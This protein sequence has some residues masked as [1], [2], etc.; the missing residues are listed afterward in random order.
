M[1]VE[2]LT[3]KEL[4]R[5]LKCSL[6]GIRQWRREGMPCRR[7][8]KLIRFELEKVLAWFEQKQQAAA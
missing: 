3:E 5:V 2:F 7:F 6:P 8:G 1:V 4:Q